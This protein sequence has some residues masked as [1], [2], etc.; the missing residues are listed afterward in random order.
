[1]DGRIAGVLPGAEPLARGLPDEDRVGDG[2]GLRGQPLDAAP[3]A[4]ELAEAVLAFAGL[5][6][7]VENV[8]PEELVGTGRAGQRLGADQVVGLLGLGPARGVWASRSR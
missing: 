7:V 3:G 8:V 4:A 6:A 5:V 2:G 1:M